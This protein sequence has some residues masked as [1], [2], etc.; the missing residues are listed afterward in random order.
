MTLKRFYYFRFQNQYPIFQKL[1][2][3]LMIFY[4]VIK[5]LYQE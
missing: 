1:S 4:N 3:N 5:G 2:L